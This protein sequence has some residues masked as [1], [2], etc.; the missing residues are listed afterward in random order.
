MKIFFIIAGALISAGG[1][2][3]LIVSPILGLV[4]VAIGVAF[5]VYGIRYRRPEPVQEPVKRSSPPEP[6]RHTILVAGFDYRQ[7]NLVPLLTERNFYYDLPKNE[8][9]DLID[10]GEPI[11]EYEKAVYPLHIQAEPDN[12]YDPNAVKVFAGETFVGYVPRG[13]FSQIKECMVHDPRCFVEIIGGRYKI[14]DYDE[15]ADPERTFDLKYY[16][17]NTR[18]N[19]VKAVM[20][21]E[22]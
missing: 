22:W 19:P 4:F 20:V 18:K 13:A 5:L 7:D 3:L 14:L 17:L 21:F 11:Y 12:P 9:V 1:L 2:I 15:D 8:L 16:R 10:D 6:T